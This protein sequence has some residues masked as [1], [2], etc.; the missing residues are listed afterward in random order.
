MRGRG[1]FGYLLVLS[2]SLG[3]A[4][5]TWT[6]DKEAP[7]ETVTIFDY[8]R[9]ELV[10]IEVETATR[11]VEVRPLKSAHSGERYF[12]ITVTSVGG[13]VGEYSDTNPGN[14]PAKALDKTLEK[15]K[16]FKGNSAFD[17][18]MQELQP[19]AGLRAFGRL[20]E[21]K[22]VE[23]GLAEATER[24]VVELGSGRREFILGGTSYG[25]RN[26]YLRDTDTG[27]VF[28][29]KEQIIRSL[30]YP[31]GRFME[32]NLHPFKEQDVERIAV[33][34]DDGEREL[35][36]IALAGGR[37]SGWADP[38]DREKDKHLYSNW[39]KKLFRLRAERY[40]PRDRAT[41]PS[42]PPDSARTL[43]E[44]RYYR[45]A[46]ELGFLTLYRAAGSDEEAPEYFARSESTEGVVTLVGAVTEELLEDL[47]GV[48]AGE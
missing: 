9:R 33:A 6:G 46:K 36:H 5:H 43:C 19:L 38:G 21:E 34:A 27:D 47:A 25:D 29:L 48:I 30:S 39:V 2:L 13:E 18:L 8:G 22:L 14:D 11:F 15:I 45:R 24:F 1:I 42:E 28:M 3:L 26:R 7:D 10:R 4:Y 31:E 17:E 32:K 20:G 23:F 12:W 44:L 40:L 16:E 41:T 35:H 37:Y